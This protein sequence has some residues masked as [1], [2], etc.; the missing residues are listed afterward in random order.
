MQRIADS[1]GTIR[2]DAR[3][4][5][6]VSKVYRQ[7]KRDDRQAERRRLLAEDRTVKAAT[8]MVQTQREASL[9]AVLLPAPASSPARTLAENAVG[10][11]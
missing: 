7:G 3:F 5:G 9:A 4:N 10:R 1:H 6:L 8:A 2:R 11:S